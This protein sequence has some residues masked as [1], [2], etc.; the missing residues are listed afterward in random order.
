[1]SFALSTTCLERRRLGSSP[2]LPG[3]TRFPTKRIAVWGVHQRGEL[4]DGLPGHQVGHDPDP[5]HAPRPQVLALHVFHEPINDGRVEMQRSEL[6]G[7]DDRCNRRC[8]KAIDN[9]D[10]AA[11]NSVANVES[12]EPM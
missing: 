4:G 9:D 12:V 3:L 7:R 2:C 1:M 11:R 5:L 8:V 6:F 10:F